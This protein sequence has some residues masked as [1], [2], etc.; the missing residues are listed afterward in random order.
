MFNLMHMQILLHTCVLL[1]NKLSI[2]EL[3]LSA[4]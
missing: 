2:Q 4:K 3:M 1:D